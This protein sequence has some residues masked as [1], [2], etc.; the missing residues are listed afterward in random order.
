MNDVLPKPFT[1]DSLLGMLEK[2]L[3]HLRQMKQ[4]QELGSSIPTPIKTQQR[5]IELPPDSTSPEKQPST[6]QQPQQT[7]QDVDDANLRFPYDAEF[8]NVFT[9][10]ATIGAPTRQYAAAPTT[11]GA[12]DG[13][14]RTAGDDDPYEYLGPGG[15]ILQSAAEITDGPSAAKK[16]RYNTSPW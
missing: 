8:A 14:R 7:Q 2:H 12:S 13:K 11:S 4:M 15:S 6:S 5:L 1:K 10:S 16:A 3:L 9:T